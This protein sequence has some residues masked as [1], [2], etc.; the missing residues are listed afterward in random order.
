VLTADFRGNMDHLDIVL[1]ARPEIFNHNME[2]VERLHR[3]VRK[4]ARYERSLSV[5]EHSAKRGFPTKSGIMLG[6]GERQEEVEDVL[7]DMHDAG[8]RIVTI[9]QYL[10]PTPDH[11][12]P[13]TAGS[14]PRNLN[15]GSSGDWN[16][17]STLSSPA[18]SC[19][20]P[21]TPTNNPTATA[22]EAACLTE[23]TLFA[24]HRFSNHLNS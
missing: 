8:V 12:R 17:V 14:L 20:P 21:T 15:T 6:I 16:W 11:A 3:P 5:L 19:A 1:D 13:S 22:P 7:T 24:H 4:T 10:Q 2:T 9:G 23:L 18:H